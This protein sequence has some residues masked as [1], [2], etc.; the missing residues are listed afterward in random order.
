M[1]RS[2]ATRVILKVVLFGGLV[3]SAAAV[4]V[5]LAGFIGPSTVTLVGLG[6]AAI[7]L[8]SALAD[9]SASQARWKRGPH[10]HEREH[11]A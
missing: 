4:V 10:S 7:I 9:F 1:A 2:R 8:L 3:V 11:P 6:A 5:A